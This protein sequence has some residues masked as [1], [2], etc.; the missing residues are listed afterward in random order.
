MGT[1]LEE[2][3]AGTTVRFQAVGDDELRAKLRRLGFLDGAVDCRRHLS[4]GPVVVA[5]HGTELAL[6]AS[7]AAGITITEVG[8]Q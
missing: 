8:N 5:R 1:T 4:K 2:V 6:G 7:V 3:K